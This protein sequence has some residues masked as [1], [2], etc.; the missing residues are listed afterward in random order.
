V[1]LQTVAML[2]PLT[3]AAVRFSEDRFSGSKGPQ[4]RKQALWYVKARLRNIERT[5]GPL[6]ADVTDSLVLGLIDG[7][8]EG[9]HE[10]QEFEDHATDDRAYQEAAPSAPDGEKE[11]EG[12]DAAGAP[13]GAA[14]KKSA[15]KKSRE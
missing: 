1:N 4:K 9:L 14:R 12:T 10:T 13:G 6:A 2:L 3:E 8:V 5:L 7:H 15:A 11:P